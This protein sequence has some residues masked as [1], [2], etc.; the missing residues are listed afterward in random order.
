MFANMSKPFISSGRTIV[1]A[2]GNPAK[3]R[4][5]NALLEDCLLVVKSLH[6]LAGPVE[7]EENGQTLE[8]NAE[9][10]ARMAWKLTRLPS[11]ADDTGLEVDVLQGL[12][13]VHSARYAGP[14]AL[15]QN[16]R[17][18]LLHELSEFG[19][20]LQRSARFRTVLVYICEHGLRRYEGICEG[21]IIAEERGTGGFGYDP[22]FIPQGHN[23]TFAE[24]DEAEKNLISHRGRALQKFLEEIRQQTGG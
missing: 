6:D 2:T 19:D 18:K 11:L 22:I 1:L 13:G 15:D 23:Q 7:I 8:E 4:E 5:L 14:E 16:N 10:K 17:R 21:T 20:L 12:P 9:I 3:V 24:M